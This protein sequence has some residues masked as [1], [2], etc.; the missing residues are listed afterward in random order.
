MRHRTSTAGIFNEDSSLKDEIIRALIYVV[1]WLIMI[2]IVIGFPLE[3]ITLFIEKL[4]ALMFQ[5]KAIA[6]KFILYFDSVTFL[7]IRWVLFLLLV[8]C[9]AGIR[10]L[11][12]EAPSG[13]LLWRSF[14]T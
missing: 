13:G 10:S 6:L 12:A 7:V 2:I 9:S 11:S 14:R 4:N 3:F 5:K 1:D 8:W